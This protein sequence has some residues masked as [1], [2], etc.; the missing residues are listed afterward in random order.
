MH[1]IHWPTDHMP[2]DTENL[3]SCQIIAQG[4]YPPLSEL[5]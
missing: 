3:V 5:R 4:L 2:G 1:S